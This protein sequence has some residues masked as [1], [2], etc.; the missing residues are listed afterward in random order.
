MKMTSF[1]LMLAFMQVSAAVFSQKITYVN[2][3]ATLKQVFKQINKQTGYNI[4]W[5]PKSINSNHKID[6]TFKN[7]SI[8]QVLVTC[9]KDFQLTYLIEGKS[10][11]IKDAPAVNTP[12]VT[13]EAAADNTITGTVKN[14]KGEGLAGV[15]IASTGDKKSGTLTD[16][17]G[18]FVLDVK[19]GSEIKISSIGYKSQTITVT[20]GK[21]VYNIILVEDVTSAETV[22]VTAYGRKQL[23]EAIVGAVTTVKPGVLKIPASNL[24]NALAGQVAGVIAYTPSGQPGQDNAKFFIRGVTTFGYKQDPLILID[25]VELTSNDLARLNVDDI[26]SFSVLKDAS[27]TALYGA[28]GGNGVIL[29]KT[30]EGKAGKAQINVRLENSTSQS[31]KTLE[32]SDPITYMRLF[33]EATRTRYPLNPIPYSENKIINTQATLAHAPG[34]NE[35]VYP[36]VD[37]MNMLFK[38]RAPTQRGNISLQGGGGVARYY[39]AGSFSNDNGILRTDIRNNNNNNVNY[40]NYQLRSNVNINITDKTELIVRLSGTFNDY[41]GPLTSDGSLQTQLYN[42][43]SHTSPVDFPAYYPADS[44]NLHT[45]HILFGNSPAAS[46]TDGASKYINPYAQLLSGHQ[47]YSE[48]RMLAQLELNQN[49]SFIT[50]GLNF[51]AIMSTNRYAYFR[52][53][54]NYNPYYYTATNYDKASNTYQ[55][56]WINNLSTGNNVAREYLNY[57]PLESNNSTFMYLQ[58]VLDYAHT[59]GKDHNISA[60]LIGTRQQTVNSSVNSGNTTTLFTSLPYR[61]QTVAGRATYS[62][63]SRYYLEFNFGYNGSERFSANHRQGFFPTIGGSWIISDEKFWGDLYNVFDRFKLRASYGLVGNDAISDRR[64]FYLSDVNLNGGNP[65]SF[66]TNNAYYRPGV[67]INNYENDDVTWEV[68]KQTNL[69]MEFT[70]LKKINVIAEVYKNNKYNILQDRASIPTTMGLE[71]GI[72]A[73]IG[74][75]ESKGIDISLDGKQNIGKSFSLAFRGNFTYSENKFTQYEAP[76]YPEAYRQQVGQPINRQYGYIAER[77]FVDDNE[78]ANS[79]SQIFSTGGFAPKGGDIKYR[80]LNGDGKIDAADQTFIGNP[81]LPQMVYGFGLSASY[82]NF[83]LSGFFQG[84]AKVSFF[85]DPARTSPFIKSPDSYYTGNTQLLKAYADDHWS[86]D[87]QNLF[88]LYPRLGPDGAVIENNRQNSNWWLRDG[89]FMRLKSVELGYTLPSRIAKSL[90]VKNTR[91]YFNGLNLL[92][93]SPFKL[94]DPELGGNGFAYPIQKV[95]NVGINVNL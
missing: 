63:K 74:K 53:Y 47:R 84:Q 57:T 73:N 12:N 21:K 50:Q 87:H 9:L 77:L 89:S 69:G 33:N 32:L 15:T 16:N 95:F 6:A 17:N 81:T 28:R 18:R 58:G 7:A 46:G 92:T 34:S 61:N 51:H 30:K 83:D 14:E 85:I 41:N 2:K 52:S 80:D 94:W 40:K 29:V 20:A 35:F 48:S 27:A 36:A 60:A 91:I 82:K 45:Q 79:P 71:S 22:V 31:V 78:A 26:E 37:W 66:G 8:D 42:L 10:V 1:M 23:K 72:S 54:L 56:Q 13:D 64:F 62:F 19:D 75:A 49:L 59:F 67:S 55:L 44:A 65:A 11:I 88:A 5:S 93:W 90:G 24:T 38:K 70:V 39:V 4:F 25:N 86:E 68:S 43:A 76:D 3:D